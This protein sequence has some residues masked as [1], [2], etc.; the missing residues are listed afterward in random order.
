VY[1]LREGK[2]AGLLRATLV[3]SL[4]LLAACIVAI[5]AKAGK[6]S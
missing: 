6:P 3:C 5:W 1:R 2:G 4:V